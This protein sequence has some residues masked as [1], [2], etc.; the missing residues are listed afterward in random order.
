MRRALVGAALV[1]G[2][3]ASVATM[4]AQSATTP[5]VVHYTVETGDTAWS[6]IV[7]KFCG[8]LTS[9]QA[10]TAFSLAATGSNNG[11]V[12][13]GQII[14]V[15]PALCPTPTTT[16]SSNPTTTSVAPSTAPTT[17]VA[18]STTTPPTTAGPTT[19]VASN[20]NVAAWTESRPV[21]PAFSSDEGAFRFICQ[22]SHLLYD[23]PIV[24]PN[25]PGAAHLHQFFGNTGANASST[26]ASLRTSGNGTCQAG[27]INRS[28]YWVPALLNGS[29]Q[30]VQPDIG[31]VYYK[32]DPATQELPDGLRY[33]A[34]DAMGNLTDAQLYGSPNSG[35]VGG[36][37]FHPYWECVGL[38][39]TDVIPTNCPAGSQLLAVIMFPYCW[40][41][42]NL[43]S[44]NH[45]SH[46]V[47]PK[48][49]GAGL[50]CPPDHP[51]QLPRF[52]FQVQW[53]VMAG[54]DLATWHLSSDVMPGMTHEPGTT[55]HAD[56][57]GAWDPGVKAI[58]TQSCIREMRSG[59]A[60]DFCNGT[61]GR[62]PS[63]W[64]WTN[65][66]HLVPI[67]ADPTL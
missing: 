44:A 13:V 11:T 30:V 61:G 8:G 55:I 3:A 58:W 1:A 25:Q 22:P 15:N 39:K 57:F 4:P 62:Q 50:A 37:E 38:P 53:T 7:R 17:S 23:D 40:D 6:V 35:V 21:Q 52:T 67:P 34:G 48:R 66:T 33:L 59:T 47:F 31:I 60:A 19:T 51:V 64:Y 10:A 65:P 29:G 27:P 5:D 49:G 28:A 41:G 14:H 43:D 26:F 24:Y 36:Y 16:T 54:D 32:G 45:R 63:P 42:V 46:V 56:W 2:L 9:P 12:R 18:P 20:V